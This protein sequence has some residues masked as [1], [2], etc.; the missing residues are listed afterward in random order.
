MLMLIGMIMTASVT[1][2]FRNYEAPLD[3]AT[4][5]LNGSPIECSLT[6]DI[7]QY[8]VAVFT[9]AASRKSNMNF[10]LSLR[11]YNPSKVSEAILSSEPPLWRH[12]KLRKVIGAITLFPGATPI[13]IKNQNAWG[14]LTELEQGMF[15]TFAYDSWSENNEQVSVALSAVQFQP[16]YD[17]FLDCVA[18]L[19]PYSFDDIAETF[20]YF[21]F[22]RSDF[23]RA[24]R[25]SLTR[26]GNW[27]E[28]DKTMELVLLAGHTDSK[29]KLKI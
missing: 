19:L 18:N 27:L 22:D 17:Q 26:I 11:R 21:E 1:A 12:D 14:L 25:E 8:G 2:D 4:W 6:Q 29:G 24:T 28:V 9:S 10:D 7:P 5:A 16:V 13:N 3:S 15:P 23:T 20:V